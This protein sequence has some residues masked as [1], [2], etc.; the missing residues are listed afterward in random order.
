VR[1]VGAVEALD[2]MRDW[3]FFDTVLPLSKAR[4]RRSSC[5][6]AILCDLVKGSEVLMFPNQCKKLGI[7]ENQ[8]LCGVRDTCCGEKLRV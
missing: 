3:D 4:R 7:A 6:F 2:E 8:A 1:E 5:I